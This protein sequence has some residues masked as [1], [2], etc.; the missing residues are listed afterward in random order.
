MM[1]ADSL[2]VIIIAFVRIASFLFLIPFLAGQSIPRMAK[3]IVSVGIALAVVGNYEMEPITSSYQLIGYI[4]MQAVI[5]ITLAKVVEM[6]LN[7]PKLAGAVMDIEMGFSMANLYDP[8]S[9]QNT[10]IISILMNTMFVI[11]FISMGGIQQLII[12]V[13]RSFELTETLMYLGD[14]GFLEFIV[15]TFGYMFV[16]AVQIALPVMGAMFVVNF[17]LL[18]IGKT[19]PQTQIFVNMFSIKISAGILFIAVITPI[20]ND[21][22]AFLSENLMDNYIEVFNHMFKK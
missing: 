7:I 1:L 20:L 14:K 17:V 12:S 5:G 3:I 19:A 21:V 22:F 18:L 8:I 6:L 2:T 13:V 15:M 11:L 9:K 16:T 10:T 4:I